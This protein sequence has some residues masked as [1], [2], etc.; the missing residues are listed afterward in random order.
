MTEMNEPVWELQKIIDSILIPKGFVFKRHLIVAYEQ[1]MHGDG[2]TI[3]LILNQELPELMG[4]EWIDSKI[5]INGNFIW[6]KNKQTRRIERCILYNR[7]K[8]A[9]FPPLI[10]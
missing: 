3:T 5:K 7:K 2:N 4:F 10:F 9:S 6:K 8:T 1:L